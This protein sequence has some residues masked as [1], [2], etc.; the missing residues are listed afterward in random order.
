M[1][2]AYL[3]EIGEPGAFVSKDHSRFNTSAAFGYGGFVLHETQVNDFGRRFTADKRILFKTLIERA[4]EKQ[5]GTTATWEIKGSEYF[6]K[7]CHLRAPQRLRVFDALVSDLLGRNGQLF[8]YVEEKEIGTERQRT[9]TREELESSAMQESLNR[10]A[11][12]ADRQ[13]ENLLVVMDQVNE[14][15]RLQRIHHMYGHIYS[16]ST[17]YGEMKRIIEPPMHLDS[18]LSSNI[19][20]A[21]WVAGFVGRAIDYQLDQRSEFDWICNYDFVKFPQREQHPFTYESKLRLYQRSI[22]D[23]HNRE[24]MKLERPLFGQRYDQYTDPETVKKMRRIYYA[25][26]KRTPHS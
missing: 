14:K 7:K 13:N 22:D 2:I 8:Y 24:I 3:D 21:D 15:E 20:F 25:G 5:P 26:R 11:R 10:L 18:S 4:E 17:E 12:F 9:Q 16:R 19:Q 1:L 23:L 6:S